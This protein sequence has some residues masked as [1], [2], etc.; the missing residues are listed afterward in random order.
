MIYVLLPAYNEEKDLG[1]LLDEFDKLPL[2]ASCQIVVVDDGSNDATAATAKSHSDKLRLSVL[3]HRM[4]RGLGAALATGFNHIEKLMA[5][6]DILV[7]MDSD[8]SHKPETLALLLK[9]VDAG[10]DVC[11]ASRFVPGSKTVG[12]PLLRRFLSY[13]ASLFLKTL[14]PAGEIS[15]YTSGYRA[16]SGKTVKAL[17]A[18]YGDLLFTQTGFAA[19]LEILLKARLFGSRFAAVPFTLR[20]DHKRGKSKMKLFKTM[21]AYMGLAAKA[22]TGF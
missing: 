9:A 17:S 10:A 1:L 5:P 3:T 18:K 4:N 15:D 8:N 21:G 7:T 2:A 22:K 13:G 14:F 16:F 11:V 20:Y 19:T 12:V 6:A